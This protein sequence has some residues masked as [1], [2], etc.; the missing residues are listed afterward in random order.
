MALSVV[1]EREVEARDWE[2]G[3]FKFKGKHVFRV[4]L[5]LVKVKVRAMEF[6][7]IIKVAFH[8]WKLY[9]AVVRDVKSIKPQ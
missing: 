8:L 7:D 1:V 2:R 4:D 5:I 3:M 9:D 6:R